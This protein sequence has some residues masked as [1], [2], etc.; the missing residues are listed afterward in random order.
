MADP[1]H[2]LERAPSSA[3]CVFFSFV[4]SVDQPIVRL[5]ACLY[6]SNSRTINIDCSLK[7]FHLCFITRIASSKIRPSVVRLSRVYLILSTFAIITHE[8]SPF[9]FTLTRKIYEFRQTVISAVIVLRSILYY[10]TTRHRMRPLEVGQ[11]VRYRY[12][13]LVDGTKFLSLLAAQ[14]QLD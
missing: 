11:A 7:G 1:T 8:V 14:V 9:H 10:D 12:I 13:Y 2:Y 5:F 6:V 4:C 3:E